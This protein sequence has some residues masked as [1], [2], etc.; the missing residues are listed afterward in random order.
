[1]KHPPPPPAAPVWLGP[2][3][4][5]ATFG[6]LFAARAA[7]VPEAARPLFVTWAI[8]GHA[9]AVGLLVALA[10]EWWRAAAQRAGLRKFG[11]DDANPNL[12]TEQAW[13]DV[14]GQ[15]TALTSLAARD[16][17]IETLHQGWDARLRWRCLLYLAA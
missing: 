4:A 11:T 2:L 1:M 7:G 13:Q 10:A 5:A 6:G 3:A 17:I 15:V 16:Q 8:L 9:G 14:L 12:W